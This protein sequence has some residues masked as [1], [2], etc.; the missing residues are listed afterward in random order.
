[1]LD[2]GHG[3]IVNIGS[4]VIVRGSARAPI[5]AAG[6]Y[7]LLGITKSYAKALAPDGAGQHVRARLHRHRGDDGPPGQEVRPRRAARS[8]TRRWAA[9]RRP[10]TLAGTALFLATDDADPHHRQLHDLRRRLLHARRVGPAPRAVPWRRGGRSGCRRRGSSSTSAPL[11]AAPRASAARVRSRE[12]GVDVGRRAPVVGEQLRGVVRG[13]G[14]QD[15][16]S[17]RERPRRCSARACGRARAAA[18]R[19]GRSRS[20]ALVEHDRVGERRESF[21]RRDRPEVLAAG[22]GLGVRRR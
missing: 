13:V 20:L 5:Y 14:E 22:P 15:A 7:G 12:L 3:A 10:R 19:P 17:P 21:R 11:R 9:S 18:S 6:K 16:R 4:T 8:A 2:Q 1:M